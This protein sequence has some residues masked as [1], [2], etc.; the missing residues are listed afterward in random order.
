MQRART[1]VSCWV[2]PVPR[3]RLVNETS[4]LSDTI[5]ATAASRDIPT[6]WKSVSA[7]GLSGCYLSDLENGRANPPDSDLQWASELLTTRSCSNSD[8]ATCRL[9]GIVSKLISD[10]S[11]RVGERNRKG[12]RERI[13]NVG[14]QNLV[15]AKTERRLFF[16]HFSH[17][18][19][20]QNFSCL[21]SDVI[22]SDPFRTLES[23]GVDSEV[24]NHPVTVTSVCNERAYRA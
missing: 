15:P 23:C 21:S 8:V 6:T 24:G 22:T 5:Q 12:A 19:G 3:C 10:V 2:G 18:V 17:L 14:F 13:V 11:R 7:P 1:N 20:D 9:S 16:G 4:L